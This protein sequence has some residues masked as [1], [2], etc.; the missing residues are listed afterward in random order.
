MQ[1]EVVDSGDIEGDDASTGFFISRVSANEATKRDE[2]PSKNF[3]Y[4]D[5]R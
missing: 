2:T 5:T 1:A 4:G 3:D